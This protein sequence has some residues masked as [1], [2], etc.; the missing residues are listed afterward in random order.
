MSLIH[1]WFD[2]R[3]WMVSFQPRG[4]KRRDPVP[5]AELSPEAWVGG[6][7][8]DHRLSAGIMWKKTTV[9]SLIR[10]D[11]EHNCVFDKI[12]SSDQRVPL[13]HVWMV[14]IWWR[15]DR[16]HSSLLML[17]TIAARVENGSWIP[18]GVL[19]AVVLES[20]NEVNA[21]FMRFSPESSP[22]THRVKHG[23]IHTLFYWMHARCCKAF[24][25]FSF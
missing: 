15:A 12:A 8:S 3:A 4:H 16:K 10:S 21:L 14:K 11:S 19:S 13:S 6:L 23:G 1:Q 20:R 24:Y 9:D 5:A 18:A 22:H 17:I 2:C 25:S 7:C